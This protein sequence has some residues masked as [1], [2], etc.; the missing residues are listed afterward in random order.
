[1]ELR[2]AT[3]ADAAAL[4]RLG[5]DSFVAKFGHLYVPDDLANFLAGSHSEAKVAKEIADPA[6]RV[7][8]AERDGHLLGYCKLVMACGWPEHARSGN[9]IEL[10]QLYT[11]PEATGQGIGA[12]LMD[13]ALTE[14]AAFGAG[15]V[16]LSVYSDN[17]GA[18]KFYA[19]YGFEKVADI[20]FMVGE[21]RDEEFLFAKVL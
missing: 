5:T 19:R 6:M 2:T 8:L 1:M 9:V 16:Q 4:A 7:M 13:W 15:E 12:A 18:Q 14:A 10:K 20:H 17:P 21:Q 11:A 3:P